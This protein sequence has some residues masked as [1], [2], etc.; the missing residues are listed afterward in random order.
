MDVR[1]PDRAPIRRAVR[2]TIN[3]RLTIGPHKPHSSIVEPFNGNAALMHQSMVEA[4]QAQQ[5]G[6]LRLATVAPVVDVVGVH[7]TSIRAAGE[8]AAFVA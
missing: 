8:A 4:A 6:L 3:E 5:I 1:M 7:E 2:R